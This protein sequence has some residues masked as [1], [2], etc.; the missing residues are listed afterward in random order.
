V[1]TDH[2]SGSSFDQ[3]ASFVFNPQVIVG[4]DS[5]R[6]I[7]ASLTQ[8]STVE[9]DILAEST[10][11][12]EPVF[13]FAPTGSVVDSPLNV[14]AIEFRVLRAGAPVRRLRL[15]GKR[16][17][18]GSAEGCSIRLT[19]PALRP[20]H[21]VLIRDQSRILVRAYSVP[22]EVNGIRQT[23]SLLAVG[24]VLR[25]G[26]YQF[27]LLAAASS[28]DTDPA[29]RNPSRSVFDPPT[30]IH[31]ESSDRTAFHSTAASRFGNSELPAPEDV[32]WRDR[33]RREIDQWRDRQI[34][35]DRRESR[36][37]E[38]ESELRSRESELWTR[39]EN[40]YR[41]ESRVQS[42][43]TAAFQLYEDYGQRQ[44]ELIRLR[45]QTQS[46]Q[47]EYLQREAEFRSQE[48]EYRR[49]LQ[50]ATEQLVQSQRQA[51]SATQSVQRMRE[52]FESLN[53]Q[54][55]HLQSQQQGLESRDSYYREEHEELRRS[56]E[57]QRDQAINAQAESEARRYEAELRLAEM[58]AQLEQLKSGQ[59]EVWQTKLQTSENLSIQLRQQVDA[60]QLTVA[61]ASLEAAQLRADYEEACRSVQQLQALVEQSQHRGDSDRESWAAEADELRQAVDQLSIDLARAN[62]E[63][64][65]LRDSN[66]AMSLRLDEA[67]RDR[68]D[69][70]AA[71]DARPTNHAFEQLRS[72]LE[73]ANDQLARMTQDYEDTLARLRET[74][75]HQST[76]G[77][78][79]FGNTA[80][81]TASVQ[82]PES[83]DAESA[84]DEQ[85]VRLS[86]A[87]NDEDAWPTYQA[88]AKASS[89][90]NNENDESGRNE[91]IASGPESIVLDDIQES[92]FRDNED[93]GALAGDSPVWSASASDQTSDRTVAWGNPLTEESA[94]DHEAHST[95]SW[96][97]SP[98]WQNDDETNTSPWQP[99]A[100]INEPGLADHPKEP[101]VAWDSAPQSVWPELAS[102][103]PEVTSV[104]DRASDA[105]EEPASVWNRD[106]SSA[107]EDS[108]SGSDMIRG[109]LASQLIKDLESSAEESDG[110]YLMEGNGLGHESST[111]DRELPEETD[112][113][114]WCESDNDYAIEHAGDAVEL[115]LEDSSR[116]DT[117]NKPHDES[118]AAPQDDDDSIEAYMNRLLNRARPGAGE[119]AP[120]TAKLTTASQP[121]VSKSQISELVEP[122]YEAPLDPDAP[123]VPRSQAPEKNSDLSA[124]REL[125]NASARSAISRSV[126][127]QNRNIQIQGMINYACGFGA[128]VCGIACFFLLEGFLQILAIAMTVIIAGVCVRE[129]FGQFAEAKRRLR[130]AESGEL[131][132]SEAAPKSGP[133]TDAPTPPTANSK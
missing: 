10:V 90:D 48:F 84:S 71:V 12:D 114:D 55:E 28:L 17:T 99:T 2:T 103:T 87:T 113:A 132:D 86:V 24:D 18:F 1:S 78:P 37:D 106:E 107:E 111:W 8:S 46:R 43:E 62:S 4:E 124:M 51:E 66:A 81:Q 104:W 101:T 34:E 91:Y 14:G 50:E 108:G 23:E 79:D 112:A 120:E 16:Y 52:Q 42:Q 102:D 33:L 30:A 11:E 105:K 60:L 21:A 95:G 77:Q 88:T 58:A 85:A 75:S 3:T 96:D 118:N 29:F 130:A 9:S 45:E 25:L 123:L 40:L 53:K 89:N 133:T 36:I 72:E 27:E 35:C 119:T 59:D 63:L 122:L 44:Q 20:M 129:G 80:P 54:I 64:S 41:R 83:E 116:Q 6:A 128:L 13:S 131:D 57:A 93:D 100:E 15:T 56:L 31:A 47:Q 39:A 117:F 127:I 26:A 92:F 32:I 69:A 38:R 5:R 126:R 82:T 7:E 49:K 70:I 94:D 97:K 61:N 73:A 76:S 110:T 67:Q 65:E 98:S 68:D 121:S 115:E 19:D 125:A 74:K 109:S 22:I